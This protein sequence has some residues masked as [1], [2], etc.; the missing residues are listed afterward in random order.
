MGESGLT[1]PGRMS[2]NTALPND[3]D[4]G[5]IHDLLRAEV[6]SLTVCTS[7]GCHQG[8]VRSDGKHLIMEWVTKGG[9]PAREVLRA[10]PAERPPG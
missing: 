6:G 9:E 10:D 8:V 5:K 2:D 4:G 3:S 1:F 7:K